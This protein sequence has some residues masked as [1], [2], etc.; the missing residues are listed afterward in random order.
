MMNDVEH[1]SDELD[2]AAELT[3]ILGTALPT[4]EKFHDKLKDE[5]A[6]RGLI[7]PRDA[8]ILWERHILNSSA[9]VPFIRKTVERVGVAQ[10]ADVGSGGGFPG[11]VAAACLRECS[12][13]LIEPMERRIEWLRECIDVMGLSNVVLVRKRSEELISE[14]KGTHTRGRFAAVT[15]RAVAPMKKLAPLTLPLII[16]GGRLIALKGKT[17]QSDLD[18]AAKEISSYGGVRQKVVSAQIGPGIEPTHIVLVD[19]R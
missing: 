14:L 2:G 6:L 1:P 19:K 5:G 3:E 12:F 16:P 11:L 13:T 15:C 4:L 10:V 7:G 8:P 9:V 18:T 17:A